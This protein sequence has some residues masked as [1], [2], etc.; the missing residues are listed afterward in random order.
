[1]NAHARYLQ[2]AAWTR[3]LRKYL[4]EKAGF[5]SAKRILEVGCGTGAILESL[6]T[7]AALHGLD[8]EPE[9]LAQSR[10]HADSAVLTCGDAHS[11]PFPN[12][13]FDIVYCHFL[14]LWVKNPLQVLRE[15]ARV[16]RIVIAFAEPDYNQRVD[17]PAELHL[18]GRWQTEALTRRGAN[19][20]FGAMLAETFH[21]A[22]IKLEET[23]PIQQ[24]GGRRTLD[25]WE[26]E[27]ATME[28][29][30]EEFIPGADI[31]KMKQLDEKARRLGERVLYVPTFFAWGKTGG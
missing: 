15:M 1:M 17:E 26:N 28:S 8:L 31:Q 29:D 21:Q 18:L 13:T 19:P 6:Q 14:L 25:E 11:L 9:A 7:S 22:G 4:F 27:W 2:Q 24:S 12:Q 23:G 5:A 30:L 20:F 16:G 3:D 10:I